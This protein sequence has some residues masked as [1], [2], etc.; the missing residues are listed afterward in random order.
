MQAFEAALA[1][2]VPNADR[3]SR[4]RVMYLAGQAAFTATQ[5]DRPVL[6]AERWVQP[7]RFHWRWPAAFAA[8]TTVAAT[9]AVLLVNR[10]EIN[11]VEHDGTTAAAPAAESRTAQ[12][13]R[14]AAQII[15]SMT[16]EE[17]K[18]LMSADAEVAQ[19][20]RFGPREPFGVLE[21]A[22]TGRSLGPSPA[23]EVAHQT[24]TTPGVRKPLPS[25]RQL[26]EDL[27]PENRRPWL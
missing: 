12:A 21:A 20:G 5:G 17:I 27:F 25:S 13:S 23:G 26:I 14:S 15:A 2:L 11:L 3:L 10:P 6:S 18:S 4:D 9:L 7:R 19:A 8:M 1:S 22:L 16:P 24:E